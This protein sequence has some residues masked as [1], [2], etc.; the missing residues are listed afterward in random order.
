MR[1]GNA[2]RDWDTVRPG[3]ESILSK[4][5][6][7]PYRQED[8]YVAIQTGQAQLYLYEEGW[9]IFTV[10]EN[11]VSG[12]KAFL[13]WLASGKGEDLI[14]KYME[15]F[16]GQARQYDCQRLRVKTPILS[17]GRKLTSKGWRCD[18]SEYSYSVGEEL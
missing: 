16:V 5:D 4:L 14:G 1:I 18:M 8:V 7:L 6:W 13:C 12:E 11:P 10:E 2:Q 17:L 15:Y 3:L 9:C